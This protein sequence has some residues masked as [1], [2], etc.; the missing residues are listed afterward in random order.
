MYL[1]VWVHAEYMATNSAALKAQ[2]KASDSLELELLVFVSCLTWVLGTELKD[3]ARRE[4]T[5]I[6][7]APPVTF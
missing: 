3:P 4:Y 2:N 5:F 1:R 6:F 7:P